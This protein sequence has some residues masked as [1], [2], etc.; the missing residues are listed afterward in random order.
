MRQVNA[1]AVER[2]SKGG[3]LPFT[4]GRSSTKVRGAALRQQY[5]CVALLCMYIEGR[6]LFENARCLQR[7]EGASPCAEL[8]RDAGKAGKSVSSCVN[9]DGKFCGKCRVRRRS[10]GTNNDQLCGRFLVPTPTGC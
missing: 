3:S 2:V 8:S 9:E 1:L 10:Q 4:E 6:V 7:G 5:S